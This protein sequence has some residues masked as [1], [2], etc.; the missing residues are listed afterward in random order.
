MQIFNNISCNTHWIGFDSKWNLSVKFYSDDNLY[1]WNVNKKT[2]TKKKP[3]VYADIKV[4]CAYLITWGLVVFLV[5][6]LQYR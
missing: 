5:N 3:K 6:E 1:L 4:K 2:T